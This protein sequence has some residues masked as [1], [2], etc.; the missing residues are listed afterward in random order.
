MKLKDNILMTLIGDSEV[1]KLRWKKT[2]E[3][4]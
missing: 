2:T 3:Q 1:A 4:K